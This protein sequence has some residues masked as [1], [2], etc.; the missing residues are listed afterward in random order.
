MLYKMLKVI[1]SVMILLSLI[2]I[3]MACL[4]DIILPSFPTI[5]GEY[6][7]LY[8]HSDSQINDTLVQA[9]LWTFTEDTYFM[10]IDTAS[11]YFS[12]FCICETYGQYFMEDKIRLKELGF[13]SNGFLCV[14][15]N[16]DINPNGMFEM[17]FLSDSLVMSQ[18]LT[19]KDSLT[20]FKQLRLKKLILD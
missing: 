13:S 8:L 15:C 7:G 17:F 5:V 3:Q 9:I 2:F 16:A 12:D 14:A 10:K 20:V 11:E 6:S 19:N 1:I 4:S 18:Q